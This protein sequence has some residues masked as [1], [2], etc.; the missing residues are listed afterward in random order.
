MI[1]IVLKGQPRST[2]SLYGQ[3]GKVR[4]MK[5]WAKDLKEDYQWQV[6]Q[7]YKGELL[8]DDLAIDVVIY[9]GNK[10]KYDW[11]NVHKLTQDSLEG[12]VFEDDAQ[13]QE[14]HVIKDYDKEDPR[15][16]YYINTID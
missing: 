7:Q 16:E 12:L 3:S 6:K 4:Y 8:K 10:R 14:A 13:I 5:Q 9:Y 11:D 15:V 2:Q 1:R